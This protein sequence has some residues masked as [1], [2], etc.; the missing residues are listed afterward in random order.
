MMVCAL[1]WQIVCVGANVVE[2]RLGKKFANHALYFFVFDAREELLAKAGNCLR[3]V[4]RH[5]VVDL[6]TLKMARLTS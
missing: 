2:L 4:E 3:F 6:A 5:F 1:P